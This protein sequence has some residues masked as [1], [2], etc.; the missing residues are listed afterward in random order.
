MNQ[1]HKDVL[2]CI[3]KTMG[4]QYFS[5]SSIILVL[6]ILF[7]SLARNICKTV[8]SFLGFAVPYVYVQIRLSKS[9]LGGIK[10]SFVCLGF[11][12]N[13]KDSN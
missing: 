7:T 13:A 12:F 8:R 1:A 3:H 5:T 11:S 4:K 2:F 9:P 6:C 10:H